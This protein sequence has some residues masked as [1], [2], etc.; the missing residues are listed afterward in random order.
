MKTRTIKEEL[1]EIRWWMV[2][3]L[4]DDAAQVRGGAHGD[5]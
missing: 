1:S 5:H 4:I 3:I 2:P